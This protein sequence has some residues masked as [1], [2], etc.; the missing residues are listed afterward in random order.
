MAEDV[1]LPADVSMAL[2]H[3]LLRFA[4]GAAP[5]LIESATGNDI[6]RAL[7]ANY[8]NKVLTGI[9]VHHHGEEELLFPLLIERFPE[10]R[11]KVDLGAKQH[12]E[13]VSPLTTAEAA[14]VEWETKSDAKRTNVASALSALDK[15]LSVHLDYE[16]TAIVPLEGRLTVEERTLHMARMVRH[17]M[18]R[19]LPSPAEFF[20]TISHG[21][22]LLWEAVGEASFRDMISRAQQAR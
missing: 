1:L 9:E 10:E 11:G 21:Q 14:L 18:T 5:A 15:R 8:Y 19:L 3:D 17:H 4:L 22:A 13:V 7:V 2:A 20:L 12:H 16:E 6:R